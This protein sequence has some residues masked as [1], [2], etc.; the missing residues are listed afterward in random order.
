MRREFGLWL[1][2]TPQVEAT[3]M[4]G[5]HANKFDELELL[6]IAIN[7]INSLTTIA[8]RERFVNYLANL[9]EEQKKSA[10][11]SN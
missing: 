8:A 3:L 2:E 10:T 11:T 1:K 4:M 6:Q 9:V 7:T 5:S